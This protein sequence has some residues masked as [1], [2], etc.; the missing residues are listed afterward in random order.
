MDECG[1]LIQRLEMDVVRLVA[2]GVAV[3][4][5]VGFMKLMTY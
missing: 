1:K 3:A 2:A 5:G 4:R